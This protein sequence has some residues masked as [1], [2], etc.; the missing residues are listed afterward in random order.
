MQRAVKDGLLTSRRRYSPIGPSPGAL[1]RIDGIRRHLT[2]DGRASSDS[3]GIGLAVV[4]VAIDN[5][6]HIAFSQILP[7][8]KP[9]AP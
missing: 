1:I 8:R 4:Q 6:S 5:A 3:G 9:T 7:T 2:G